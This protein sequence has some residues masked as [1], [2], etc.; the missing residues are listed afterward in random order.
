[1][2]SDISLLVGKTL[3]S[4]RQD[5]DEML[6]VCVD[7]DAFHAYHMQDCCERVS[8]HDVNG[9]VQSLVGSPIVEA[10]ENIEH[11]DWPSDV[12]VRN[13]E[14]CTWTTHRFVTQSGNIVVVRWLGESNGYYSERVH[15]KRTHKPM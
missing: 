11:N 14:S 10:I 1:M 6:F 7:G 2:N 8:I 3:Q 4:I 5:E 13:Y 12:P 15:F 9:D